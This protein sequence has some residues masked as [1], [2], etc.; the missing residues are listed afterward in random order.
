MAKKTLGYEELQWTCPNCAGINPGAGKT[1]ASCGAPQ[2]DDVKFEQ[3]VRSELLEDEAAIARAKVG[4]DIHCPYC[5]TRNPGNA[6]I[7]TQCGG[8]LVSG[9]QRTSGDVLGAFKTGPAQ[10]IPCPNCGAEN[11]DTAQT[12]VQCGGRMQLPKPE[13]P[14]AAA[15]PS[16]APPKKGP[17]VV[18]FL[19]LA[20]VCCVAIGLIYLL[21]FR[22]ETVNGTVSAVGWERSVEIEGLG[23]VT[24]SNWDD[25]I[26]A[27]AEVSGCQD[28]IRSVEA[29]PQPGAEEV[30]GTPY[31]ED[32]GGGYAEVVQDCEYHVYDEYCTYSVI[33]WA[34]VDT[35]SVSGNDFYPAWPEPALGADQRLGARTEQYQVIFD[36]DRETYAYSPASFADWQQFEIGSSWN[37]EV[38][39]LGGVLSVSP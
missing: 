16:Q 30:C 19:I 18:L 8:D 34:V 27:E 13:K 1:C 10:Q 12:C 35:A 29:E 14:K 17:P 4:P 9:E 25:Q 32:T 21:F 39:A 33:E 23:P 28:E 6:E 36:A 7:C 11:P 37:L 24:Y 26:P 5:G 38:N 20:V 22:S 15:P 31:S 2:P 3:A